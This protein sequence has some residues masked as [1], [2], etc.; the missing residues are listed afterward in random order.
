MIQTFKRMEYDPIKLL[1]AIVSTMNKHGYVFSS[2]IES[3]YP[4]E[5]N[6]ACRLRS[7]AY[8]LEM[9]SEY[10][11]LH[12]FFAIDTNVYAVDEIDVPPHFLKK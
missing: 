6:Y 8:F 2:D 9:Y 7:A 12:K 4:P 11:G 10:F 1:N 3:A 5:F